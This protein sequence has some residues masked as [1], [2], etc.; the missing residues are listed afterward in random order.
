MWGYILYTS[1]I[2]YSTITW[3]LISTQ[4]SAYGSIPIALLSLYGSSQCLYCIIDVMCFS[5]SLSA[6]A[7]RM[8]SDHSEFTLSTLKQTYSDNPMQFGLALGNMRYLLAEVLKGLAYMHD[9]H[10][11]HRD[12]K[13]SN[14]L[15]RFHC[16]HENLLWCTCPHK[17]TVC[18]CDF[19]A[20]L[21][22]GE[23]NQ[24]LP[25]SPTNQVS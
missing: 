19:D 15:V 24:M 14:I 18:V 22:M 4:Q 17:Y 25:I 3:V 9:L 13:A 2:C 20:A 12:I 23:Q 5:L 10:I 7:A 11:I 6:D 21:E 1:C 16:Q 8:L